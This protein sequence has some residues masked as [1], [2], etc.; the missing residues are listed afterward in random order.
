MSENM[1]NN[2]GAEYELLTKVIFSALLN[3][4]KVQ[5]IDVKHDV[6]LQGRTVEHQIDVYWEFEYGGL[7]YVT[8]V[9]AK[10]WDRS[11]SQ[12]ELL[13][14]K[15][16]LD[17]LPGQ[18]RGVFVARSGYQSG[19]EEFAEKHGIIIYELFEQPSPPPIEMIAGSFGRAHILFREFPV[20]KKHIDSEQARYVYSMIME[21]TG[22]DPKFSDTKFDPDPLWSAQQR[23]RYGEDFV[24]EYKNL[25]VCAQPG[26]ELP[27]VPDEIKFYDEHENPVGCL[28]DIYTSFVREMEKTW[29][30]EQRVMEQRMTRFFETP[31]FFKTTSHLLPYVRIKA[32]SSTVT[33]TTRET[34]ERPMSAPNIVNYILKNLNDVKEQLLVKIEP[35]NK[36]TE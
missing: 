11:V 3:Q 19:A 5:N 4:D 20:E 18:P 15:A 2:T 25:K 9:Q 33:L 32:L 21:F 36:V 10:D 28:Q 17:D 8:V 13:K 26:V 34:I 30:P 22:V 35:L 16:V 24:S 23:E 29:T 1:I 12:G 7:R 14:F 27:A 6:V 31:T